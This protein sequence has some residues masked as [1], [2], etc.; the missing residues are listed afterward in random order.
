MSAESKENNGT[1]IFGYYVE[2]PHPF[3]VVEFDENGKAVSIEE[4]PAEPRSNYIV[5]GL[6]FYDNSVVEIAENIKPSARGELEITSVN[7]E[8][9]K[10]GDLNV[11]TLDKD[12]TWLDARSAESLLRSANTIMEIQQRTGRQVACLEEIAY[13]MGYIDMEQLVEV[14]ESMKK[15]AYGQYILGL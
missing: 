8:Y 6:Y 15:T 11:V 10:R 7:N 5:P 1:T 2:D 13:D 9:L 12:F 4:K 3:G 14:G